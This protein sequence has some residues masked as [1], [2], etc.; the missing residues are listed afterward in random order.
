[1]A[2][3][4]G[5]GPPQVLAAQGA[6]GYSRSLGPSRLKR[7]QEPQNGRKPKQNTP[8]LSTNRGLSNAATSQDSGSRG[9]SIQ[10]WCETLAE[11]YRGIGTASAQAQGETYVDLSVEITVSHR[12]IFTARNL[13]TAVAYGVTL[14]VELAD[15]AIALD[16]GK[17]DRST[18]FEQRS[19]M[20][21]SGNIPGTTC[22]NGTFPVG[23]LE[24]GEEKSFF[25]V[26]KL[27]P[28][29]PCCTNP[30]NDYWTVP[31]RAVI[32]NTVPGEEERFKGDNTDTA[33]IYANGNDDPNNARAAKAVYWLEASVDDLLPEAGD[34]VTFTFK[35]DGS[36]SAAESVDAKLRLKLD[37]GMGTPT[38]TPSSSGATF[39][40]ATGLTRTWDWD[41][42]LNDPLQSRT[43]E[44]STTLDDPL[45]PGMARSDLCLTAELTARGDN[46]SQRATS[47][48]I[49]LGED[50][51]VLLE[52]GQA[53]LFSIHPCVGV[54]GYPCS[55]EDTIEVR[56][57]GDSAARAAGI[58]RDE[59]VL[60]PESVLV[61][62]K[63]P[64]GRRIDTY[65]AS[66]NSGTAPSWHTA[67]PA[68]E[69]LGDGNT[70]VGGLDVRYTHRAF[71][72]EQRANY[73]QLDLTA[74]V[75]GLDGA[76]APGLLNI[77]Y[78]NTELSSDPDAEF[79]PR[80]SQTNQNSYFDVDTEKYQSFVEFSTLGTYKLDY[81]AAVTHTNGTVYSGTGRYIFHVGPVAELEVRD[82]RANPGVASDRRAFTIRAINNGPD[83][84]A[85][86]QVRVTGLH[87]GSYIS[88]SA[89]AGTFDSATGVWTIGE[90]RNPVSLRDLY[91]RDGEELTIITS[92]AADTE[93]TAAISNTQDY[94]VCIDSSGD[95]VDL[96]SPSEAAC[97]TED[98]TN[99]WHTAEYFDYISDNDSA[100]ITARAG[101]AGGAPETRPG[102]VQAFFVGNAN[103]VLWSEPQSGS[104]HRH[105]GAARSWD[106]EYSD[107]G[108]TQWTPLRYEY[109]GFGG[110][111]FYVDRGAPPGSTR[112]Y[113]VRARY[114][115][116]AGG[117]TEAGEAVGPVVASGDPGVTVSPTSLSIREG[118]QGS[119]SVRLDARPSGSVVIDVSS[120]NPDVR[121]SAN[122]LTFG[123]SNWSR[124]QTVNV[125]ARRDSDT[126]D[127]SDTI[128]HAIDPGATG[129]LEYHGLGTDDVSVSIDD[130]DVSA[131]FTVGRSGTTEIRVD[132]GGSTTYELALGTRPQQDV[133]VSLSFPSGIIGVSPRSLTFTPAN[134]NVAQ[135]V[136]VTGVQD[137][138]AVDDDLG[139]IAHSFSGGYAD[140]AWL[141]VTVIDDDRAGVGGEVELALSRDYCP[142]TWPENLSGTQIAVTGYP[143]E[144]GGCFY[145]LRLN[146]APSG[147]VT[148]TVQSDARKV[149]LDTDIFTDGNQNRLTFTRETW[150]DA[151]EIRFEAVRDPDGVH[152]N[153]F[154]IRHS[155]SGGGLSGVTIPD[156]AVNVVDADRDQIGFR[157]EGP[158][159]GVVA[160]EGDRRTS[161]D[162]LYDTVFY[163][164]PQTQPLSTV[165]V[166]MS[167][168]NPDVT[169][170]PSRLSFTR[171]NWDRGHYE[172]NPGR[173]VIVR[174]AHDSDQADETASITFTVTSSDADYAGLTVT[175]VPV[176]VTDDDKPAQENPPEAGPPAPQQTD[177][178]SVPTV[179][180]YHDPGAGAAA[181]DRYDQ[182]V[183]L[184]TGAGIA[185]AEVSGDVQADVDRLAGVTGSVLPRFFLG[186]P[187]GQGWTSQLQMNNGGLRWLQGYV[188]NRTGMAA[189][190]AALDFA[191]ALEQ[192]VQ[193][194]RRL[195]GAAGARAASFLSPA[196]A[197]EMPAPRAPQVQAPPDALRILT[198]TDGPDDLEGGDGDDVLIGPDVQ[199]AKGGDDDLYGGRGD[200]TLVGGDG[201]DQL[202]G[203]QGEDELVGGHG[204]DMYTGGPGAD[205]F[206]FAPGESGDRVITDFTAAEGDVI[207]L[208]AGDSPWP[209][210]ADI[211]ATAEARG[212]RYLVYTLADGQTVE[213]DTPLWVED[214]VLE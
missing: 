164:F 196:A 141:N 2:R 156:I 68:H 43:L 62:V 115:Q 126:A 24:P 97:T 7:R 44:V 10:P 111:T 69:D 178:V 96:S 162:D 100:T 33:W 38:G 29:L 76:G 211:L 181:V 72:T 9:I 112:Q 137:D 130:R 183:T 209:P 73:T 173:R 57:I 64:E 132:E 91:G 71:T 182:A 70:G 107:D 102:M 180:I 207:V 176:R 192:T 188:A 110:S 205:R 18:G 210:I 77:R 155:I 118:S 22:I 201:D 109:G 86:V 208:R 58:A 150:R 165:T 146:A 134:Y 15:Q 185:Y 90:M 93:I 106:I 197:I 101:L 35:A 195:R 116:R 51:V 177:R 74:A 94:Q 166:A 11:R 114:D 65:S 128:T 212:G 80:Q 190:S 23:A 198:G 37:N 148:V 206:V 159:G 193:A 171:S 214:F 139:F 32:K 92:A 46:L 113:R 153:D 135:T 30:I 119:Y 49:C 145:S 108:G 95:D 175:P 169:V 152:N 104:E 83:E 204:D 63:D 40:A 67:R 54:T 168:N 89:T 123:P 200:D 174:A 39:A 133:R 157:V 124:A 184:L 47:A 147:N 19:G 127:D 8:A 20:T 170:S 12:F 56:V 79:E 27:A 189:N 6:L 179:F 202:I 28:G 48:E 121:L 60:D 55:D 61:Q 136:T 213:T 160:Q 199:S 105:F 21:C 131:R 36:G 186:D 138:D 194:A 13:G 125:T 117:W 142:G 52:E 42:D 5:T 34:T 66:V 99:T 84:A 78:P 140:E 82:G 203:G 158:H 87:A 75:A 144:A 191:V 4:R 85:G 41:F 163:M 122:R 17:E 129:A 25:I 53:T 103:L 45:P 26:P 16:L 98:A 1:M 59:A 187:T 172:G 88:H 50:P 149:E 161:D 167:S 81:T 151:Q 31:A 120:A 3:N 154:T 143:E 14:D